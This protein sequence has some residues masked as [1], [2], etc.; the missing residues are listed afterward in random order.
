[1]ES[2]GKCLEREEEAKKSWP[3]PCPPSIVLSFYTQNQSPRDEMGEEK[4]RRKDGRTSKTF[5]MTKSWPNS[6]KIWESPTACPPPLPVLLS[7][8]ICHAPKQDY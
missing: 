4:N 8:H 5:L 3:S 1:M 7:A 2:I 6:I